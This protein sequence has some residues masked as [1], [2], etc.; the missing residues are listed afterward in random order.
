M[1]PY[2]LRLPLA[3]RTPANQRS[4]GWGFR[5]FLEGINLGITVSSPVR[6]I[7][8]DGR[9]SDPEVGSYPPRVRRLALRT[10]A[11]LRSINH[12]GWGF[13]T[14]RDSIN[15]GDHRF[16]PRVLGFVGVLKA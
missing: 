15:A 3:P 5:T 8:G 2:P 4:V 9:V 11:N 12:W 1:G 6:R 16:R 7:Y 13:H 10:S 14:V